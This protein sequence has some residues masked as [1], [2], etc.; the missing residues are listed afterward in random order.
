MIYQTNATL[1]LAPC[2][3]AWIYTAHL[4]EVYEGRRHDG[5]Q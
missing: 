2:K 1:D 4:L 3:W 5:R